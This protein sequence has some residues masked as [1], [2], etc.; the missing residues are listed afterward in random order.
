MVYAAIK[1]WLA[2]IVNRPANIKTTTDGSGTAA[3]PEPTTTEEPMFLLHTSK[4]Q[5]QPRLG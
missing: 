3:K 5:R 4:R 1:R 2:R